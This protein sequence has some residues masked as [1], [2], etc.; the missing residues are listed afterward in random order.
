MAKKFPKV[1]KANSP[2]GAH[3]P[4]LSDVPI[5]HGGTSES[6]DIPDITIITAVFENSDTRTGIQAFVYFLAIVITFI[7]RFIYKTSDLEENSETDYISARWA[8]ITPSVVLTVMTL[9]FMLMLKKNI[10]FI[11]PKIAIQDKIIL[12]AFKFFYNCMIFLS[13][14]ILVL[15]WLPI[16][17]T[18]FVIIIVIL[19][20]ALFIIMMI[21]NTPY[22][23]KMFLNSIAHEFM[24]FASWVWGAISNLQWSYEDT[25]QGFWRLTMKKI[26]CAIFQGPHMAGGNSKKKYKR[27]RK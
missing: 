26:K 18:I 20:I 16:T 3:R 9:Y 27:R 13:I 5:H 25:E 4:N 7:V 14:V 15:T 12:D 21:V 8:K 19:F 24:N 2:P 17:T 23:T 6:L 11:V 10:K 1:P 22:S